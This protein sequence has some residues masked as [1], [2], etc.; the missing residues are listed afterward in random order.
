M[1]IPC[2]KSK[3]S[4]IY[5]LIF[6]I[7][8][9]F[10]GSRILNAQVE[11]VPVSNPVYDFLKRM[12]LEGYIPEYN[13][14][15]IPVSRS[16]VADY[17]KSIKS[18][19]SHLERID[20][21]LLNDYYVEFGYDINNTLDNN[22]SFFGNKS[23]KNI[24]D[25]KKQKHIFAYADSTIAFFFD[26][27]GNLSYRGSTG[28]SI[29]KNSVSIGDLNFRFRGTLL[30]SVGFYLRP[31]GGK[32]IYGNDKASKFA[33]LTD[34][35][36]FASNH[37]SKG[38]GQTFD[39][40]EGYLRY[41]THNDLL[42]VTLG[43]ESMTQGFGYI[44][45]MLLSTNSVPFDFVR[46]DLKYKSLK[47]S[48]FYGALKGDSL[49]RDIKYKNISMQRLDVSFSNKFRM[50]FWDAVVI[51]DNAFSLTYLN[52]VSFI[53]S[54]DINTDN[55]QTIVNNTLFALDFEYLPVKNLAV[56]G[57]ILID[58]INF[59]TFYNKD[60]SSND[61]KLAY[62]LGLLWNRPFNLPGIS[63]AVE[64]IKIDPFT[65][66]HR[67]N[68]SQF[69]NWQ[70]PL[71]PSLSPNSD[72][73]SAKVVYD[74]TNRLRMDLICQ[75]QRSGEGL[76]FD[77]AGKLISNYGGYIYRGDFDNIKYN[78]FLGGNRINR[79]IITTNLVF[80]PVRQYFFELR[81]QYKYQNLIY[82][83]RKIKDHI[84]FLNFRLDF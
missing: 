39:Y 28:D 20:K 50:G 70:M 17:L 16:E 7:S 29:G 75:F 45:K 46:F 11:L 53:F 15:N 42:A 60:S 76:E 41:Q 12:Q 24:F 37:F 79:S 73:I 36:L 2:A 5:L 69:T 78:E 9:F 4:R 27:G 49:S 72:E 19:Y 32:K 34:P 84:F 81:Y 51:S 31:T 21:N 80:Q 61:N 6:I 35:K 64:Y 65:Y 68:K 47:Y 77:S 57:A 40:F 83:N 44:D 1:I 52:P 82:L 13:S 54:A 38:E 58:D 66:S 25:D 62:Q 55:D 26:G 43:R 63:F 67:L 30:N 3:F 8:V 74:I 10:S 56:Q 23:S 33:S 71:G 14:G 59:S 48:F 22:S 18:N